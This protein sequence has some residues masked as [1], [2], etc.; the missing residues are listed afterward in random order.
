MAFSGGPAPRSDFGTIATMDGA[1]SGDH[2]RV[3]DEAEAELEDVERALARLEEGTY[4]SCE[5]C[6]RAIGDDRLAR[7][8][9]TRRCA[10]H[11]SSSP[12]AEGGT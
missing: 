10:Q 11:A 12:G 6:G 3:L 4:A 9:A 7:L 1:S 5:A 8:P 2:L